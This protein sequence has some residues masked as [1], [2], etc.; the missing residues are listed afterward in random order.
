MPK[1]GESER[2]LAILAHVL[3]LF[4]SF[5]AP[6]IVYLTTE[7]KYA[8]E[9]AKRALNWQLS[10]L[11]YFLISFVLIFIVIGIF[12]L[13]AISILDVVFSIIAAVRASEGKMYKYP[14]SIPFISEK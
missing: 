2:T 14:L 4:A 7:N 10:L 9:H 13:I 11:I 5:I 8:K 6:L 3:G 12:F 1:E